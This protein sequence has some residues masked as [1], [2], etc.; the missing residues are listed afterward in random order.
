VNAPQRLLN[1]KRRVFAHSREPAFPSF[2]LNEACPGE[3]RDRNP[4]DFFS[5]PATESTEGSY[6][7][8]Y[9]EVPIDENS[10]SKRKNYTGILP[11]CEGSAAHGNCS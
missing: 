3:N 11:H 4:V 9:R 1:A 7:F 10:A 6:F 2:R 8:V 5:P